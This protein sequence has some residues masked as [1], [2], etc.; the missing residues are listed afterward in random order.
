MGDINAHKPVITIPS[1]NACIRHMTNLCCGYRK[2][3]PT[4]ETQM[5]LTVRNF[6]TVGPCINQGELIRETAKFYIFRARFENNAEKRLM[7]CLPGKWS[8]AHTGAVPFLPRPCA[9]ASIR[10]DTRTRESSYHRTQGIIRW[11]SSFAPAATR[12]RSKS[13]GSI[14]NSDTS[15]GRRPTSNV[16]A[17]VRSASTSAMVSRFVSTAW[18]VRIRSWSSRRHQ[19]HGGTHNGQRSIGMEAASP[20]R[21]AAVATTADIMRIWRECGLPEYF[22]GNG[23]TNHKLVE[24][25][26]LMCPARSSISTPV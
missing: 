1:D 23:G 19:Q 4:G 8:G 16:P 21:A 15:Q 6:S 22:L 18:A 17:P 26:H 20:N 10:T 14:A 2:Q 5:S 11:P 24:F 12:S 9:R 3:T 13:T 7:K 25:A